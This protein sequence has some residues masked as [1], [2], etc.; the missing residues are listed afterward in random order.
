MTLRSVRLHSLLGVCFTLCILLLTLTPHSA[1]A[2]TPRAPSETAPLN[3]LH[4]QRI[5]ADFVGVISAPLR[6]EERHYLRLIGFT[7]L[8][9]TLVASLDAPLYHHAHGGSTGRPSTSVPHTLAGLG[10]VYDRVGTSNFV[11]G[12]AGAFA[13]T[14]LLARDDK[15]VRTSIRIVEAVA[16]TKLITGVLKSTIGRARPFTGAPSH[17]ANLFELEFD[18]PHA[19]RSMPS[20]HTSKIFAAASVI[21][22]QYDT[23]WVKAPA[24]ATA[25]SAGIQR[26]ES[27]KH[28]FSDV[29]VG[30]TLGYL[31]GKALTQDE[32][33]RSQNRIAYDPILSTRSVGLSLRF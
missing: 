28:W 22:H 15:A 3:L 13:A 10:R 20:G 32:Q 16:F 6:L 8:T 14:G 24:Y 29:V 11:L 9:A 30:A 5:G 33:R 25:A 2:Q 17:D 19:R 23:W 1:R 26:I 31:V 21:A 12:T 18:N 4:P 27:G 7:G